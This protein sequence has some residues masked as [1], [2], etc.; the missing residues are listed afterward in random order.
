MEHSKGVSFNYTRFMLYTFAPVQ[1]LNDADHFCILFRVMYFTWTAREWQ[2]ERERAKLSCLLWER[3]H[4]HVFCAENSIK[5]ICLS[6]GSMLNTV[7][8][9]HKTSSAPLTANKSANIYKIAAIVR[10]NLASNF[11]ILLWE[12][13][14]T[15]TNAN[16]KILWN[17]L[18]VCTTFL[19]KYQN[20][21]AMSWKWNT[22]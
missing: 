7:N 10:S 4:L 22:D 3:F 6:A 12:M 21:K 19:F 20:T 1:R 8:S 2:R 11:P 17:N 14:S 13:L 16:W 9:M 18:F 5:T 15:T